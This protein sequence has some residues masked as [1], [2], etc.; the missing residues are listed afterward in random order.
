MSSTSHI[1]PTNRAERPSVYVACLA[2]Y[3]SGMLHGRWIFADQD[4]DDIQAEIDEML[5]GSPEPDAEE[6]AFH[7]ARLLPLGSEYASVEAVAEIGELVTDHSYELIAGLM[8]QLDGD[9][10]RVKAAL[11]DRYEG[12]WTSLSDW[13]FDYLEQQ[14][15]LEGVPPS[16]AIYFDYDAWANDRELGAEIF[17]VKAGGFIHVFWTGG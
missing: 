15:T 2:S 1:E 5:A 6:Y 13:A 11:A 16:L 8:D 3:S 17:T 10:A 14:G 7:D 4:A 12:W 9:P